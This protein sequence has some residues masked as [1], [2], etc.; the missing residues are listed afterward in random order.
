MFLERI[1]EA[2]ILREPYQSGRIQHITGGWY[3]QTITEII[4]ERIDIIFGELGSKV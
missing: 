3:T 2:V 4:A 1:L